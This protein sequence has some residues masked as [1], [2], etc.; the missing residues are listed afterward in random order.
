MAQDYIVEAKRSAIP[1][2]IYGKLP[3]QAL[4]VIH[5]KAP[6]PIAEYWKLTDFIKHLIYKYELTKDN[7]RS[8]IFSTKRTTQKDRELLV[9]WF[10]AKFISGLH[11]G[12][13]H[14]ALALPEEDR[15]IDCYIRILNFDNQH[16]TGLPIQVCDIPIH[17][18]SL[19]GSEIEEIILTAS[20]KAK[21]KP[22]D[23]IDAI[24]LLHALG[25][26]EET[27]VN[28][29]RFRMRDLFER[30]EWPYRKVILQIDSEARNEFCT[31][32]CENRDEHFRGVRENQRSTIIM[33]RTSEDEQRCATLARRNG[34]AVHIV[35]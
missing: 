7:F 26:G 21:S 30:Q 19:D 27:I 32:Y 31:V 10:F 14:Y 6:E 16:I 2:D 18:T 20:I 11:K 5:R 35:I 3:P 9:A 17:S 25:R 24:L 23:C 29:D 4:Y 12:E 22:T 8:F 13:L 15:G 28:V 34:Q 33:G 1:P